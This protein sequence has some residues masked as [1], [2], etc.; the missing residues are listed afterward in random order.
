M[1][2]GADETGLNEEEE[3]GGELRQGSTEKGGQAVTEW[4]E[5]GHRIG[6]LLQS[7]VINPPLR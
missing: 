3:A 2:G 4:G 6:E 7:P 5:E 1:D